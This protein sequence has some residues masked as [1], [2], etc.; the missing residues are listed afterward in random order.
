M[1]RH[2]EPEDKGVKATRQFQNK[3]NLRIILFGFI[4]YVEMEVL[5]FI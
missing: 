3:G 2:R 4:S 5:L 1:S